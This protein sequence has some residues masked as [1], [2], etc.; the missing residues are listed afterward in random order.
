MRKLNILIVTVFM[1]VLLSCQQDGTNSSTP[2]GEKNSNPSD[3]IEWVSI[4]ELE[5]KMKEEPRKVLVDLY[6]S[7]CGWCKRMDK[8]T[9][10]HPEIAKYV[11]EKFYAVKFNAETKETINF[12]G[13]DY[14]FVKKPNSRRGG[15]ELA[16]RLILGDKNTGRVGYPTIVFLDEKLDR[17]DAY[18][19]YKDANKFDPVV[20]YIGEGHYKETTLAEFQSGYKSAITPAAPSKGK[21]ASKAALT[22]KSKK[23]LT[24][25]VKAN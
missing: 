16:Y 11:N 17:I 2:A 13:N 5:S 19:G 7:W 25:K 1:S 20:Q 23:L 18:P 3:K 8:A 10:A 15:N 21:A 22:P 4:D 24:P 6:T 9:F 14:K 12:K